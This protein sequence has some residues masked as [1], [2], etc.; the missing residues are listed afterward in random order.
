MSLLSAL[1]NLVVL[2]RL[3]DDPGSFD[4]ARV[5]KILVVRNDNI[6]DV[7]CTTPALDALRQA[8]PQAFIAAVVC[9]LAEEAL[10]G[11]RALDHLWAYPK[12]KHKQHGPLAS[13]A[14]LGRVLL[15]VR[16]ERFDLAIAPR[17]SFSSSQGWIVYASR[18]RWRLGPQAQGRKA[19]WGFY[20]N[21]PA[22][23][24]GPDLHEVERCFHLLSH[25]QVDS[26]DKR[27][28]LKVPEAAAGQA[29]TFLA[30]HG[31]DHGPGPLVVNITRW[32]YRPDRL[33]PAERYR[34]LVEQLAGRPGGVVVTHA[35]ADK[36][37]VVG[38]LEGLEV[39]VY[40]SPS[41][42][43][44]AALLE[45]GRALI[46]AEG[47]PMHLAAALDRPLVVLWGKTPRKVWHPW[48]VAHRIVGDGGPVSAIETAQVL[49]ALDDLL[50]GPAG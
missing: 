22:R 38:L 13:L 41:L 32:A 25:I 47:G 8:F 40:F 45:R 46:T 2:G 43:E 4:P 18:A 44:F 14:R 20:Y 19:R 1:Y 6:G 37:W 3:K 31:L 7:I 50:A 35:P 5:K 34:A 21:L 49:T 11:H 28:Y 15:E 24:P 10:S 48:G 36:E 30:A 29:Q 42:K 9:T 27:L 12:A 39:P 33:W 23:P 17:A 16:R 26:V